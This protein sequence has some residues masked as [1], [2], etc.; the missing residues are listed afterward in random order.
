MHVNL[1]INFEVMKIILKYKN[2]KY[3]ITHNHLVAV[4]ST[5]LKNY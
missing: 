1:K 5:S 2:R 4:D 3:Q